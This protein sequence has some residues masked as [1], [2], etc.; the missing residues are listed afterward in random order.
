MLG[1][2]NA[3]EVPATMANAAAAAVAFLNLVGILIQKKR[4][5]R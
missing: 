1:S 2:V 5:R 3:R 4:I